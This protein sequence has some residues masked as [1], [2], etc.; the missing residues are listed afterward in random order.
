MK[1]NKIFLGAQEIAGMME[2]LNNAFHKM[3]IKSDFFCLYGYDYANQENELPIL[4]KYRIH[5]QKRMSAKNLKEK[6]KWDILQMIDILYIF[7]YSIF[8]Y[9]CY[10]YIFGHGMFLHNYYLRKVQNIEFAI[11]KL[12]RK[13]MLMWCC[14]SDSRAPYCNVDIYDGD[15]DKMY[16]DINKKKNN[17]SMIEKYMTII[18]FPASSHFHTKPYI[19]YNC[20]GVPVDEKEKV[21]YVKEDNSRISILHAPSNKKGKGTNEIRQILNE[22]REEG[23]DFDYVEVSGMPHTEVLKQM[24]KADIVIDQL[25]C[26]TPMAGFATEAAINGIPVIVGGYYA[27]Q[28]KEVLPSPIAPTLFCEPDEFKQKLIQLMTDKKMRDEIGASEKDYVEKNCMS[29]IVAK[30]FIDIFD[31]NIPDNYFF[32]PENNSYPF[33]WGIKKDDVIENVSKIIEKYG[34]DAL[35]IDDKKQLK[36]VYLRMAEEYTRN[37]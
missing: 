11:L 1:K 34:E 8:H 33:G 32:Q 29:D 13:K 7:I 5:T 37:E 21:K 28:Y 20:L 36:E 18:D 31:G 26:D 24:V 25:Y 35:G 19:I 6:K 22:I 17:I 14:G 15:I 23:Y 3:G 4:N 2:R 10:L 12:F 9:N 16:G 30:K 27:K